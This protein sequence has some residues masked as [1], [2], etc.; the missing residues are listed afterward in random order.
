MRGHV[1]GLVALRP[2]LDLVQ[3]VQAIHPACSLA[4]STLQCIEIDPHRVAYPLPEHALCAFL[5]F[6]QLPPL[7]AVDPSSGFERKQRER[8]EHVI[9]GD[10]FT[11]QVMAVQEVH[12]ADGFD[13]AATLRVVA[14]ELGEQELRV[15]VSLR[16]CFGGREKPRLD[17]QA[18]D[19]GDAV[20]AKQGELERFGVCEGEFELEEVLLDV[21][22]VGLGHGGVG[23]AG[24]VREV[25]KSRTYTLFAHQVAD[26]EVD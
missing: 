12:A 5:E 13:G 14:Q 23:A 10:A 26:E 24:G 6:F 1:L 9:V 22:G 11:F 7:P 19:G 20:G 15:D 21:E 25:L 18:G 8:V 16:G 2:F 4:P 3:P 17:E